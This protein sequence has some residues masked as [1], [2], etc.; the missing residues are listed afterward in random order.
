V[1]VGDA[2]GVSLGAVLC[3]DVAVADGGELDDAVGVAVAA[4]TVDVGATVFEGAVVGVAV[5]FGV[6]VAASVGGR[7]LEPSPPQPAMASIATT[8]AA[9][10][11]S[12]GNRARIDSSDTSIAA[13][14][15]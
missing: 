7:K 5:G 14:R 12:L 9:I 2:V 1:A 10:Q 8:T 11:I 6:D 13:G 15:R 4:G 3:V